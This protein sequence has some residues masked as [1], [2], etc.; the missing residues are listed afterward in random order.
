MLD[1]LIEAIPGPIKI[2]PEDLPSIRFDRLVAEVHF[3]DGVLANAE[4]HFE[5]AKNEFEK[6]V[7]YDREKGEFR[8]LPKAMLYK[9]ISLINSGDT[10]KAK[11]CLD[12][13]LKKNLSYGGDSID[14]KVKFPPKIQRKLD[15][16]L[17]E[18][19]P[20][21]LTPERYS[22]FMKRGKKLSPPAEDEFVRSEATYLLSLIKIKNGEYTEAV[23]LLE[24]CCDNSQKGGVILYAHLKLDE[25]LAVA[26][27]LDGR[28]Q[29]ASEQFG[30]IFNIIV[31]EQTNS[32]SQYVLNFK[33]IDSYRLPLHALVYNSISNDVKNKISM[34]LSELKKRTKEAYLRRVLEHLKSEQPVSDILLTHL[35]VHRE[36]KN[37]KGKETAVHKVAGICLET[38]LPHLIDLYE[39]KADE[40]SDKEGKIEDYFETKITL[41]SLYELTLKCLNR[42]QVNSNEVTGRIEREIEHI[43]KKLYSSWNGIQDKIQNNFFDLME[44]MPLVRGGSHRVA[45]FYDDV[46]FKFFIHALEMKVA[47]DKWSALTKLGEPYLEWSIN[48]ATREYTISHYLTKKLDMLGDPI[49]EKIA[50]YEP[51]G[52]LRIDLQKYQ[53]S[54]GALLKIKKYLGLEDRVFDVDDPHAHI[55]VTKSVDFP[56]SIFALVAKSVSEK[57]DIKKPKKLSAYLDEKPIEKRAEILRTLG[58]ILGYI[59]GVMPTYIGE[60]EWDLAG[61]VRSRLRTAG[62][63]A[64]ASYSVTNWFIPLIGSFE[65]IKGLVPAQYTKKQDRAVKTYFRNFHPLNI[66]IFEGEGIQ[67]YIRAIDCEDR[68]VTPFVFDLVDLIEYTNAIPSNNEG[69]RLRDD[70]LNIQVGAY[71]TAS[72][73]FNKDLHSRR[74]NPINGIVMTYNELRDILINAFTGDPTKEEKKKMIER[75]GEVI[76]G[77]IKEGDTSGKDVEFYTQKIRKKL[78]DEGITSATHGITIYGLNTMEKIL[79][80]MNYKPIINQNSNEVMDNLKL[81]RDNATI[82]RAVTFYCFFEERKRQ[83][84][85]VKELYQSRGQDYKRSQTEW[86]VNALHAIDR[87]EKEHKAYYLDHQEQYINLRNFLG[88]VLSNAKN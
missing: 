35:R 44:K 20:E 58:K 51:L 34:E 78:Q 81:A 72:E 43:R 59:Q 68:G 9:A 11:E 74:E 17:D 36:Y 10:E 86:L 57:I 55:L 24:G 85:Q 33:A 48:S 47:P 8:Y 23:S 39:T 54:S 18:E 28:K 32:N 79:S 69:D 29:K 4:H 62:F 22:I 66:N 64:K 52:V 67:D 3:M 31:N 7:R 13:I 82:Y 37:N 71:N 6:A 70:I 27:L 2:D 25:L 5:E 87:L 38:I 30:S 60:G 63:D 41:A 16:K 15:V 19:N 49:L 46:Y 50:R 88:G 65:N 21:K 26:Y 77:V 83:E 84:I 73:I 75:L 40:M 1:D 61:K 53:R 80:E 76:S 42:I 45:T 12:T 14:K 56:E